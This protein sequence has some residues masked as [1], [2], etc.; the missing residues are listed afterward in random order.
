MRVIT[1]FS[2]VAFVGVA[3]GLLVIFG[4]RHD[5][6]IPDKH[7]APRVREASALSE[8]KP[9]PTQPATAQQRPRRVPPTSRTTKQATE[10]S[11]KQGLANAH[12]Y[13]EFAH[14][15][16]PA[17]RAG[18]PDA[19]Y[20]LWNVTF[21]CSHDAVAKF[22]TMDE[23]ER[24]GATVHMPIETV[25]RMYERCHKLRSQDISDLGD[26]WDWLNRAVKAGQPIAQATD[27]S[28][29][30]VQD[31]MRVAGNTNNWLG[32]API[33][34]DTDPHTLVRD[35]L[36]NGDPDALL[37]ISTMTNLLN[38]RESHQQSLVDRW[39]WT[40]VACQRGADC[41]E[42]G[43]EC[44]VSHMMETAGN[45][46]ST[47]QT[48]AQEISDKLDSEQWDDLGLGLSTSDTSASTSP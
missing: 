46:W 11:Y 29:Q 17:A 19:Q 14:S 30:M 35:A 12:D 10:A 2:A 13:F 39:A 5:E 8:P 40:M 34:R 6:P 31:R 37:Q 26:S 47:V 33:A 21:A 15:I 18:N 20:Y 23:A 41:S 9:Q 3:I 27:A 28:F 25:H 43:N 38:P 48:R 4:W 1:W 32:Q 44:E 36:Q 45:A 7:T 16:L 42:C 24:Y 22:D